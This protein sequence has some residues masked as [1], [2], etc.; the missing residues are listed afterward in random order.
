MKLHSNVI[1]FARPKNFTKAE[2]VIDYLAIKIISDPAGYKKIAESCE[3]SHSTI[4]N[5]A[6]RQTK[7]PRPNTFFAILDH[8]KI[9]LDLK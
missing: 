1:N 4:G 2:A 6:R 5:I 8:Y 7:W 9:T 3:L